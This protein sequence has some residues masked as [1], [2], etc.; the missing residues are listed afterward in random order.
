MFEAITGDSIIAWAHVNMQREY[1]FTRAAAND[2]TFDMQRI[3][4]PLN[5]LESGSNPA[6][7]IRTR[8]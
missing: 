6:M 4:L 5:W 2:D 7:R 1:D 3:F 8:E